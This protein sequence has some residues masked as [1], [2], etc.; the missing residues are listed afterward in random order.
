MA[1]GCMIFRGASRSD[2]RVD[3]IPAPPSFNYQNLNY[4]LASSFALVEGCNVE[5]AFNK[6]VHDKNKPEIIFTLD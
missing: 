5:N 2:K 1:D 4:Q 6:K 3:A